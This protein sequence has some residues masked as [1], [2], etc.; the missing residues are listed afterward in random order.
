MCH[1][2]KGGKCCVFLSFSNIICLVL[3]SEGFVFVQI[4]E[5]IPKK[6]KNT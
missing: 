3:Q 1:L 4:V 2:K 5:N 6:V